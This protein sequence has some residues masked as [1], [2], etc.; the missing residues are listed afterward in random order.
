MGIQIEAKKSKFLLSRGF[1]LIELIVVVGII[2]IV[3][4]IIIV[5]VNPARQFAKSRNAQRQ[6]DTRAI[7]EALIQ[8]SSSNN[9]IL[10][11]TISEVPKRIGTT[12]G[13]T[14]VDLSSILSPT[15]LSAVPK[16]PS[17]GTDADTKY[18]V[19]K[20]GANSVV[21]AS[22]V[23]EA[24][25]R[26][27]SGGDNWALQFDGANDVVTVGTSPSFSGITQFTWSAW[28]RPSLGQ[29]DIFL[30][31]RNSNYLR[32]L[33][34]GRIFSSFHINGV[35]TT[36]STANPVQANTW[37]HVAA[38]Y[39]GQRMRIYINGK[40]EAERSATGP[41][42][43]SCNLEFGALRSSS[44]YQT[45]QFIYTGSMDDVRLYNKALTPE[46]VYEQSRGYT[47]APESGLVAG[48]RFDEGSGQTVY[49]ASGNNIHGFLGAS[50]TVATDDPQWQVRD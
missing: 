32:I 14:F 2:G 18:L 1:T 35:Q 49:D 39:D 10:P 40:L 31:C 13:S 47:V 38:S 9:G 27:Q 30:S 25:E 46:E 17:T 44:Y 20:N 7:R 43:L 21:V 24:E 33:S 8:Y 16:D 28:I 23:T 45:G 19:F 22:E 15:Y 11:A 6:S 48:Y 12:P 36:Y 41:L 50:N 42:N 34:N 26:V 29:D 4:T 37:S 5:A 3:A